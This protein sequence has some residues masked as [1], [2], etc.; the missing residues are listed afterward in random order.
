MK[1]LPLD[2]RF[3]KCKLIHSDWTIWL[4]WSTK[5]LCAVTIY[6]WNS[7][8]HENS[9]IVRMNTLNLIRSHFG[10]F[11]AQIFVTHPPLPHNTHALSSPPSPLL[12]FHCCTAKFSFPL[13]G[14]VL[15]QILW[16]SHTQ[17]EPFTVHRNKEWKDPSRSE[18]S[19]RDTEPLKTRF[20]QQ[21]LLRQC[22]HPNHTVVLRRKKKRRDCSALRQCIAYTRIERFDCCRKNASAE[23]HPQRVSQE[24]AEKNASASTTPAPPQAPALSHSKEKTWASNHYTDYITILYQYHYHYH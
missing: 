9:D 12:L 13:W 17:I 19:L 8:S 4:L 24:G 15:T 3:P 6:K 1:L 7:K 14:L 18:D 10:S 23:M 22:R 20:T 16:R 2:L 11:I 5:N 21:N